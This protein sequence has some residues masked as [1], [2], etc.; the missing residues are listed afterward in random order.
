MMIKLKFFS[1]ETAQELLSPPTQLKA[2]CIIDIR[3]VR[4]YMTW[5]NQYWQISQYYIIF[6]YFVW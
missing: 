5:I 2:Q 3:K 1:N 6:D 4:S